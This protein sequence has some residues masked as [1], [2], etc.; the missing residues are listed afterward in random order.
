MYCGTPMGFWLLELLVTEVK[1][2]TYFFTSLCRKSIKKLVLKNLN[3][4]SL[5]SPSNREAEDLASPADYP[6][7][8]LG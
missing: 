8:G 6:E 2:F 4:S 7:N 5:Y 1:R 3:G